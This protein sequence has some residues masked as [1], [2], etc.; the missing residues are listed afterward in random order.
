MRDVD[1]WRCSQMQLDAVARGKWR[2]ME[3]LGGGRGTYVGQ[4]ISASLSG[5]QR[6]AALI[7]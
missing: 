7:D 3:F 4:V 2:W 1:E 5:S 6:A